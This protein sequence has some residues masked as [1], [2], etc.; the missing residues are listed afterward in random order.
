M[1]IAGEL[2]LRIGNLHV[3]LGLGNQIRIACLNRNALQCRDGPLQVGHARWQ[4]VEQVG[5]LF[6][7][8][9]QCIDR[10]RCPCVIGREF[11]DVAPQDLDGL[12]GG[13]E[14][15]FKRCK[16]FVTCVS[17]AVAAHLLK[18]QVADAGDC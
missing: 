7:V 14:L 9:A 11:A 2:Q 13:I 10:G 6:D 16:H 17:R 15:A 3:V 18:Q 8:P 4:R 1:R 12:I 5:A